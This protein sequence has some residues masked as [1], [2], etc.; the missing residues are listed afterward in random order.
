MANVQFENG[1][2]ASPIMAKIYESL[3]EKPAGGDRSS[4]FR[5]WL[6]APSTKY[7]GENPPITNLAAWL[8]DKRVDLQSTF[9]RLSGTTRIEF[10][11]WYLIHAQREYDLDD[12]FV[13]PMQQAALAWATSRSAADPQGV[14]L[15]TN[16]GAYLH[17]TQSNLQKR[18]PDIYGEHR[19]DFADWYL[20]HAELERCPRRDLIVPVVLS[21]ARAY[22]A[23]Q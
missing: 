19:V 10:V 7:G 6:N 13:A 18:F 4:A 3:P 1:I 17:A 16:L 2:A 22:I 21:W 14:P 15:V 20:Y 11:Q 12:H 23:K 9:P 8:Y 5:E